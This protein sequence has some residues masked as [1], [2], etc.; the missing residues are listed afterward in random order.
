[1]ESSSMEAI[2]CA[3][4]GRTIR[5]G[6]PASNVS[7]GICLTC[8]GDKFSQPIEDVSEIDAALAEELPFGFIRLDA[9][10]QPRFIECNPL[11]GLNPESGDV[12]IATQG[13]IPYDRLVANIFH[14]AAARNGMHL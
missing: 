3:W 11:P 2:D 10:G 5:S 7:Y 9:Q 8:L 1:M 6:N 13:L 4:C 12:V 14:D